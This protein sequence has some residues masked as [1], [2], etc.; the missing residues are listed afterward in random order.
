MSEP[1]GLGPIPPWWRVRQQF[2]GT[3]DDEWLAHTHPRLPRDFDY[4]HYQ[5]AHPNLILPH[6]LL[7]GMVVQTRGLR[8]EGAGSDLQ[9]PDIMPFATFGFTDGRQVQTRLWLDGLHLDLRGDMP[10]YDLTWRSWIE[11]C[12]ALH[13]VDLDVDR[14]GKVMS[15]DLPVAGVEGLVAA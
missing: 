8:H 1:Q 9:V 6:E 10:F 2:A 5:T 11:T 14:S 12:P 4:R 3:Y 13:R 7:P 15:L